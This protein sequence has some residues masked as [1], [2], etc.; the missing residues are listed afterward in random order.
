MVRSIK[1]K[2]TLRKAIMTMVIFALPIAA[3]AA[4]GDGEAGG[5]QDGYTPA[6]YG[7]AWSLVPPLVAIILAL[8]TKE[9][10]S[11]LF[12]GILLGGVFFA[13]GADQ[14]VIDFIET[15]INHVMVTGVLGSL[16]DSY[17]MGIVLF[18]LM[19]GMCVVLMNI[20]G[21]A[22]AFGRWSQ[23]NIKSRVGA[24][25]ACFV[26]GILIFIDDYFNCLTVGSV[27]RPLTDSKNVSRAKLAWILDSTAAPVC[28]IAPISSWAAAVASMVGEGEGFITFI[29]AIPYNFYALLT[30]LFVVLVIVT[31]IDYGPMKRHE[32]NAQVKGDLYTTPDRPYASDE[33]APSENG[34][35]FDLVFPIVMLIVGCVVG[36]IYTGGFFSGDNSFVDSFANCDASVS[37]MLGVFVALFLSIIYFLCRRT[38]SFTKLMTCIPEGAK[39][40]VSALIILTFAWTIKAMTSALGSD[41]FVASI[42][43]GAGAL[44]Y[45]VPAIAF[46]LGAFIAFSTGTSWG[47]FGILIPI[48]IAVFESSDGHM[49]ILC[50][51]ACMAGAVMGD[52]CSPIS[53]T[54]IL[55]A[56]GA[57]CNHVNHVTTQLPYALTVG[58]VS[59]VTYIV[60]GLTGN[61]SYTTGIL[62]SLPVGIILL[63]VTILV[64]KKVVKTPT[65]EELAELEA[66]EEKRGEKYEEKVDEF[67]D[68]NVR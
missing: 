36:M 66:K 25:I 43:E 62:I 17:N 1:S 51:S 53:D 33:E 48:C 26:L 37:L 10:Y 22:A 59:F 32:L 67:I 54:T 3:Y 5:M 4:W 47:T 63:V 34:R 52:H 30:L 11:S 46:V 58:A 28:I 55:S 35:V 13:I 45:F 61:L 29:K 14:G 8:V 19:L 23:T 16:S 68:N 6:V 15:T 31:K 64:L 57:Q 65:D 20:S 40:M 38:M 21:G 44:N 2:Y 27:M 41:E 9:V 49:L 50:I 18:T 39:I 12:F 24:Q 56:T 60:A 7:T 42:M